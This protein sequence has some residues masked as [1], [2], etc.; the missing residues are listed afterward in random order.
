[1]RKKKPETREWLRK[2][3]STGPRLARDVI[4]DAKRFGISYKTLNRVKVELL[5]ESVQ[6]KDGWYWQ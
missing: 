1:M 4:A 6:K 5:L 2:Y 3:M